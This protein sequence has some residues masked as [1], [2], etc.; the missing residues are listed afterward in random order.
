[1]MRQQWNH[2][3]VVFNKLSYNEE[4][5]AHATHFIAM[6]KFYNVYT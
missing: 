5:P 3:S 2:V 1:M 4:F 6:H